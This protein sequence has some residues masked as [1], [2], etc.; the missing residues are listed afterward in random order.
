M[1]KEMECLSPS[2]D[3]IICR[4][5]REGNRVFLLQKS[6]ESHGR[7]TELIEFC[8]GCGKGIIVI[9]EGWKGSCWAGFVRKIRGVG[10]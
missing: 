6:H 5:G 9:P 3:T 8:T 7:F 10:W 1:A 2:G 4:M